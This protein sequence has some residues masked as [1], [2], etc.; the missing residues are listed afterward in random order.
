MLGESL[1]G[2]FHLLAR[3]IKTSG[4]YDGHLRDMDDGIDLRLPHGA[5]F[6]YGRTFAG[7]A[8]EGAVGSKNTLR[9]KSRYRPTLPLIQP[10]KYY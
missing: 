4:A 10:V 9:K 5:A 7:G 8:S 6:R 3:A 1:H 2:L